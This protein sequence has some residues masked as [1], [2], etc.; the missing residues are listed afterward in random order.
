MAVLDEPISLPDGT[1]VRI[2]VDLPEG[3]S[4]RNK[5]VEELAAEQGVK[6]LD[7]I[8]E[9]AIDW[10]KEDSIDDFLTLVREVRR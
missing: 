4:S 2:E 3:D 7:R 10:P 8:E 9:L 1:R 6:P 5:T